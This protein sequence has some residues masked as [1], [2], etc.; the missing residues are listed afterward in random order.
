[1][2]VAESTLSR[3]LSNG[4][5]SFRQPQKQIPQISLLSYN[6]KQIYVSYMYTLRKE[7]NYEINEIRTIS[8]IKY[9][10]FFC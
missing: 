5:F 7:T 8:Y 3:H 2:F 4:H 1:M 9:K 10:V 6:R